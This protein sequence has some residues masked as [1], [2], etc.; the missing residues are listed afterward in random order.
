MSTDRT[1]KVKVGWDFYLKLAATITPF[2][3]ALAGW[4]ASTSKSVAVI[5]TKITAVEKTLNETIEGRL[6]RLEDYFFN[7]Q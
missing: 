5:E 3:L 2:A 6:K 4:M 7:R 1:A